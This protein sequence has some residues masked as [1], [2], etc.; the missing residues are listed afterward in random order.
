MS[1]RTFS[2]NSKNSRKTLKNKKVM[3]GTNTPPE[4]QQQI[5][6]LVILFILYC[7]FILIM[8]VLPSGRRRRGG[9]N[10][11]T[12]DNFD[13]VYDDFKEFINIPREIDETELKDYIK[14]SLKKTG[15]DT[16]VTY[17][18]SKDKAIELVNEFYGTH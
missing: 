2:K 12:D 7:K 10:S 17:D 8:S 9:G 18:V 5:P 16:D 3:G 15:T 13:V 1:K 6:F 4:N 14:E 11:L